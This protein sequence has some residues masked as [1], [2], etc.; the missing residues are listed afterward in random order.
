MQ[1]GGGGGSVRDYVGVGGYDAVGGYGSPTQGGGGGFPMHS[2]HPV[3]IPPGV[4][5]GTLTFPLGWL[6]FSP[7]CGSIEVPLSLEQ[8]G[9]AWGLPGVG[10]GG[11]V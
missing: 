1:G 4:N 10:H 3:F 5:D 7:A 9:G 8:D 2:S 11:F 6:P